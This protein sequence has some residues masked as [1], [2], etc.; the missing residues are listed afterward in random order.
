[1]RREFYFQDE[2]S[3]KFWTIELTGS[4]YVT[5][6]GRVGAKPRET[7]KDFPDAATAE[8]EFKRQ[9]SAKLAKGYVEGP[10]ADIPTHE[11]TDWSKLTMSEDVFWRIIK[12]F[13]WKK[14]GD[15]D[16]VLRRAVAALSQMTEDDIRRFEDILASKLYALDTEAH[17]RE[18][19]SEACR[20]DK[21][22]SVDW[23]LYERCVVVA[24]GREFFEQ[25]LADPRQMPEDMEFE[26]IPTL[27]ASAFERKTGRAFEYAAQQSYETFANSAGWPTGAK[28]G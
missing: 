23:F 4:T 12:L 28:P 2:T 26:A 18:I 1:M 17:A 15:D 6:H 13:D 14:T 11:A 5:T 8:R 19:G 10:L 3:N 22:F 24:N 9:I 27:A 25:V 7:R 21:Y 16:A 20:P